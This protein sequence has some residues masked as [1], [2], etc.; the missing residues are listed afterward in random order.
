MQVLLLA[1]PLSDVPPLWPRTTRN[2]RTSVRAFS[3]RVL[4]EVVALVRQRMDAAFA[5]NAVRQHL[6]AILIFAALSVVHLA[7]SVAMAD[8]STRTSVH[9]R[10]PAADF[11]LAASPGPVASASSRLRV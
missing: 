11:R 4:S 3:R 5:S 9:L 7:K 2:V 1:G 8:A 10:L 6:R